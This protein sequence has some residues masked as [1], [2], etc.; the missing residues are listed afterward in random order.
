M[1]TA[2]R[3]PASPGQV[4]PIQ[5]R[6]HREYLKRLSEAV[7]RL[8]ADLNDSVNT[9]SGDLSALRTQLL[10]LIEA[11]DLRVDAIEGGQLFTRA[12]TGL[13]VTVPLLEHG[14]T[15]PAFASV[16]KGDGREVSVAIQ[17]TAGSDVIVSSLVPLDGHV[18]YLR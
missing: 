10:G 7:A 13:V 15:A 4:P 5:D 8:K 14:I 6:L 1:A 18:L 9:S 2:T 16:R 3:I 11:L 12:L 17:I